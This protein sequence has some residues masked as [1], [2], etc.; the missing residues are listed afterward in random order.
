MKMP[1]ELIVWYILPAIRSAIAENMVKEHNLKQTEVAKKL[2]ITD[3]AV[4]QYLSSKRAKIVLKDPK[5]RKQIKEST[6]RIVNGDEGK[7]IIETCRLCDLLKKTKLLP[8]LYKEYGDG[9]NPSNLA[10]LKC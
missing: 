8:N 1:C 2:G 5:I 3:A 4:S 9:K 10:N 7:V 6:R